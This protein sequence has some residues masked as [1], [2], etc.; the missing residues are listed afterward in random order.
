MSE[1]KI[2]KKDERLINN[3][4]S[5]NQQVVIDTLEEIREDGT[6]TL[7]PFLI[8]LLNSTKNEEISKQLYALLCELKQT[9][10]TAIILDAINNEKYAGIQETLLRICWENGLDYT[11][12]LSTFVNIVIHGDFMNSF[13]AFTVIENM[14][15]TLSPEIAQSMVDQLQS[16]LSEASIEKKSLIFDLIRIIPAIK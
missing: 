10:S 5:K 14:E 9:G 1:I 16:A 7:L 6:I 4:L 8:D 3:L 15:G 11:P 13:E 2:S 12:Y